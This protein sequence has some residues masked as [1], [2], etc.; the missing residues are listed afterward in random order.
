MVNYTQENIQKIIQEAYMEFINR[1][2]DLLDVDTNER[3]LTHRIA[4]Y[5]E[6][7]FE[8]YSID[9]EYSKNG[10]DTKVLS[11]YRWNKT[12]EVLPDI[13]VHQR[14]SENNL[15]VIEWKKNNEWDDR[16]KL[17]A[18][19]T[20]LWYKYAILC[21]FPKKPDIAKIHE[22]IIFI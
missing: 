1:D 3:S 12:G 13:I 8:W 4:V 15:L 6:G 16:D 10:D 20:D 5:L 9:C 14:K 2:I 22:Y 7:K 18:Y 21:K 17:Q 11:S 19:K